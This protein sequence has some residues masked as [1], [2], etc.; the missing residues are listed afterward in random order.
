[1]HT[2]AIKTDGTLWSWGGNGSGELGLGDTT[3]YSSPVQ[4]GANTNWTDKISASV[5]FTLAVKNS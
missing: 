4:V 1:M 2:I 5:F 3:F